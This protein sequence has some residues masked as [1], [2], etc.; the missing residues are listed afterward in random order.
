M[1]FYLYTHKTSNTRVTLTSI[2][3]NYTRHMYLNNLKKLEIFSQHN[4]YLYYNNLI[5]I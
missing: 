4:Y 2:L 1:V 3:H 5:I